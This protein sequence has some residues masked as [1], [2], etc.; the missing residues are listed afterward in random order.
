VYDPVIRDVWYW[1]TVTGGLIESR[2]TY[3]F[4]SQ[5]V[6]IFHHEVFRRLEDELRQP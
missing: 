2:E 3:R 1:D 4:R 6:E 5:P